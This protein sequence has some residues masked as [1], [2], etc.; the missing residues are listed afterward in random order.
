MLELHWMS[1]ASLGPRENQEEITVAV[2]P[3]VP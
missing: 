3:L 2:F 1:A